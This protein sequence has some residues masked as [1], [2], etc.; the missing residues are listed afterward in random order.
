MVE[1]LP[2]RFGISKQSR[3]CKC[4]Q[5]CLLN[6]LMHFWFTKFD[7][8]VFL[9]HWQKSKHQKIFICKWI[10]VAILTFVME[11]GGVDRTIIDCRQNQLSQMVDIP[12]LYFVL[13]YKNLMNLESNVRKCGNQVNTTLFEEYLDP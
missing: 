2:I 9:L 1:R 6:F 11:D 5:R 7:H 8:K 13:T 3:C 4:S 12:P 10:S